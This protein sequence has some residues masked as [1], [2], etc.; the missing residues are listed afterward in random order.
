MSM[1]LAAERAAD[2]VAAERQGQA[3]LLA[4]PVAEVEEL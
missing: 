4:P 1:G 3:G 2:G